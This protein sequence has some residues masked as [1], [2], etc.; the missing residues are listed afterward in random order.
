MDR[1]RIEAFLDRFV[2]MAAATTTIGL[3]AVADRAGLTRWLLEHGGGTVTDIADDAGLQARYVE[4]ILSGLTAAGVVEHHDGVF[5]LPPEHALVVADETSPYFMGGWLD[6][7]PAAVSQIDGV[8]KATVGGG[9]VRFDDFGPGLIRGLDRGNSPS[10]RVLLVRKWLPAVPGLVDRLESG[11]RVA[12]VG[13]GSGTAAIAIASAYPDSQ[14]TG[15][16]MSEE[17]LSLA[18][19]R[20]TGVG[21]VGFE[22][23]PVEEIP[24]E[25]GFE[26]ITAF[27]VIHDLADPLAALSRIRR[28]LRPGGQLLMME[29]NVGSDLD[30]N[31]GDVGALFYG[32]STLHCMTQSLAVGGAGVGAA[33]GPARAMEL[34]KEAGLTGFQ[35]LEEITNRFS[36]FYLLTP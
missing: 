35:P 2:G 5:T 9:G 36:A 1:A 22:R 8:A 32:I 25:P 28:A 4:E 10:Q 17:L 15:F 19:R 11:I 24:I 21:N 12:D 31:I 6:M 29:P 20:A 30:D 7:L 13:C 23:R 33:W 27:D 26:L 18:R 34:A 14:V 3:L 16:D